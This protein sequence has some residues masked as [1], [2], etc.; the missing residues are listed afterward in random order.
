MYVNS[1][2]PVS[3]LD[4]DTSWR[5]RWPRCLLRVPEE[6]WCTT[7]G[8]LTS[9]NKG[10][11]EFNPKL[12]LG[13]WLGLG[14]VALQLAFTQ[15]WNITCHPL[16]TFPEPSCLWRDSLHL[17]SIPS[18]TSWT[19]LGFLSSENPLCHQNSHSTGIVG[20]WAGEDHGDGWLRGL[21]GA[22]WYPPQSLP[23]QN[24]HWGDLAE[25]ATPHPHLLPHLLYVAAPPH[26]L[27]PT[28]ENTVPHPAP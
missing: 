25:Q 8:L 11:A 17:P 19:V 2:F 15:V 22:P 10:R 16:S 5:A 14:L 9:K 6:R 7:D 13:L 28:C 12:R 26:I 27:L 4:G 20:C 1:I 3:F 23:G 21:H 24:G 18:A